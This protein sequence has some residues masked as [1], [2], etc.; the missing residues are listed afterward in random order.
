MVL[1]GLDEVFARFFLLQIVLINEDLPTL[2]LPIKAYSGI[3]ACG[4]LLTSVLLMIK[5][6]DLIYM[7]P[8]NS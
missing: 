5:R 2:D 7:I 4:H 3:A 6:A 8:R 1:P